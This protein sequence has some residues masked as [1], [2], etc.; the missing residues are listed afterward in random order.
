MKPK[1]VCLSEFSALLFPSSHL[2]T[3]TRRATRT[4]FAWLLLFLLPWFSACEQVGR[5]GEPTTSLRPIRVGAYYWP[6]FYWL[7]IAQEKGWFKEAGLDVELVD[8]NPDFFASFNDLVEG[9][10]DLVEFSTFDFTLY[11]AR[12]KDLVAV[13]CSDYSTGAEALVAREG[14]ISIR[15]LAGKKV[16]LSKGTYLEYIFTVMAQ[17]ESLDLSSVTIVDAPAEK[18]HEEFIAGRADAFLTYEPFVA[19]GLA[20]GHGRTLF[21]TADAVGVSSAVATMRR[22]FVKERPADVQALLAVWRRT[23]EFI[24][25]QPDEAFA[26][27]ARTQK[28]TPAEVKEFLQTDKILDLHDNRDAFTYA[29]GIDSLHGSVRQMSDFIV[30]RGLATNKVDSTDVLDDRFLRALEVKR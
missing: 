27:V 23:T 20:K 8:T 2:E 25:S 30:Q 21:T 9:K 24:K 16:A 13:M 28:K 1:H 22:D 15:D 19:E 6:G 10:L 3:R 11:N 4:I 7:D 12:G 29:A 18:V 17:R 5:K 26:V 14:I